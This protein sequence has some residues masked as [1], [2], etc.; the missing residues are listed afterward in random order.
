MAGD[1]ADDGGPVRRYY[2][3]ADLPIGVGPDDFPE[4]LFASWRGRAQELGVSDADLLSTLTELTA[5]QIALACARFG[6]PSI[7]HGQTDDVLLRG[8]GHKPECSQHPA[9]INK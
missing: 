4:T 2:Q 1:R 5:K 6:G 8:G 9:N 7:T 3:Q